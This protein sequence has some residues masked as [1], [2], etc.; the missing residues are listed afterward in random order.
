MNCLLWGYPRT[1][2]QTHNPTPHPQQASNPP[3]NPATD[4]VKRRNKQGADADG[5]QTCASGKGCVSLT[6]SGESIASAP[7]GTTM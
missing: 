1:Q 4:K 7:G 3:S 5:W 6:S 2:T